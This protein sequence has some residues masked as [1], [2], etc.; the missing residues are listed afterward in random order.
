MSKRATLIFSLA[1]ERTP[2]VVLFAIGDNGLQFVFEP[3]STDQFAK[4]NAL[5]RH[6]VFDWAV[7]DAGKKAVLLQWPQEIERTLTI[8]MSDNV[9]PITWLNFKEASRKVTEGNERRYL[10]LA[11]QFIANGGKL[12]D[13]VLATTADDE[14]LQKIKENMTG[15]TGSQ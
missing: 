7:G 6:D 10:Q 9:V 5:V 15:D 14:I 1:D 11:V 8:K 12:D 13:S 4:A 2:P 3:Q